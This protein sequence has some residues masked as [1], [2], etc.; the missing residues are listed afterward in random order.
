MRGLRVS[1]GLTICACGGSQGPTVEEPTESVNHREPARPGSP[2]DG[3]TVEGTLGTLSQSEIASTLGEHFIERLVTDCVS[4]RMRDL[5]VLGG[6]IELAFRVRTDGAV[7]FVV[8]Q[9]SSL[10]DETTEQCVLTLAARQRFQRPRGGEVE[11]VWPFEFSPPEDVRPPVDWGSERVG[12]VVAENREALWDACSLGNV[13][14]DV[15]AYVK[16][17]G[18]VLA[19]GFGGVPEGVD[20]SCLSVQIRGWTFP[21]PG[22]YAAKVTFELR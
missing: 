7:S 8:V 19:V 3:M 18:Q 2:D 17:G 16:P 11:L 20:V 12:V 21:D 9:S 4:P 22:S 5:E 13:S 14:L 10:G 6:R 1:L 15:T